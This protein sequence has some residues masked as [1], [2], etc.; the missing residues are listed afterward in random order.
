VTPA[1][2][3]LPGFPEDFPQECLYDPSHWFLHE[4]RE[5]DREKGRVVGVMD[6]TRLG[7]YDRA[8]RLVGAHELHV[9]GAVAIQV[10]G[11]LGNLHATYVLGLRPSE[12]WVGY[13]THVKDARFKKLARIG[14]PVV[15]EL[16]EHRRR[17]WQ[18]SW[19]LTY[20]FRFVQDDEP[21]F[22]SEQVAVWRRG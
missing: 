16:Q 5:L 18:G 17:Q 21:V 15:A 19:F 14:P 9:P 11:T 1:S 10:T 2:T 7:G 12:G 8:Q 3:G 13:G 6:T 20:R 4:L 22:E